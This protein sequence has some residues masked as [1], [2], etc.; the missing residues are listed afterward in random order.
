VLALVTALCERCDP[1]ALMLERDGDYP[2]ADELT[3]EL[4][5]IA[6]AAGWPRITSA[7]GL[8]AQ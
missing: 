4:D 7:T 2:P 8:A 6:D 5:A 1:P 3:A